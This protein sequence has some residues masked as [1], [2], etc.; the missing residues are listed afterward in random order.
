MLVSRKANCWCK[1]TAPLQVNEEHTWHQTWHANK[2]HDK[3]PHRSTKYVK[4]FGGVGWGDKSLINCHTICHFHDK[5]TFQST[6]VF[7]TRHAMSLATPNEI[8][9]VKSL[10]NCHTIC[11]FHDKRTF[12]STTVFS[13][14]HAMSLATP[15]E[16]RKVK[17]LIN[18]HTICHFHDK[19]TFQ[20]MTAFSTKHAMSLATPNEIR[21]VDMGSS[22]CKMNAVCTRRAGQQ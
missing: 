13:T 10:I 9:K 19:R 4:I 18:C 11:H 12:Q 1:K 21:K 7:S 20:S 8:R 22:L 16:I 5:R 6:T 17:S 2:Q 3:L 15:N 14:R